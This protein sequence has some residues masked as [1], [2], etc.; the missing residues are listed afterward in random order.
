M[1]KETKFGPGHSG[2]ALF[3]P[4][5]TGPGYKRPTLPSNK[6]GSNGPV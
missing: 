2:P 1:R 3:K 6:P 5:D 4:G